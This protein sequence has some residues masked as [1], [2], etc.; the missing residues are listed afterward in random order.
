MCYFLVIKNTLT[1]L[2]MYVYFV[3]YNQD[4]YPEYLECGR[5]LYKL[6]TPTHAWKQFT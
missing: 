6:F 2:S 4:T 5:L 3:L 1:L